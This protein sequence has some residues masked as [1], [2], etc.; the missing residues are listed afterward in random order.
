MKLYKIKRVIR[1]EKTKAFRIARE[2]ADKRRIAAAK[3]VETRRARLE[4]YVKN[5]VI[6]VT[7]L[8]H[9]ALIDAAQ[10][11]FLMVSPSTDYSPP[12]EQKCVN[13]LRHCETAYEEELDAIAGRTGC[14]DAYYEIKA[15]VLDAIADKYEWL[16]LE[17]WRQHTEM[18]R[19]R[20]L[21]IQ[22]PY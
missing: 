1:I 13:F 18:E 9:D 14:K 20:S 6:E 21:D 10:Q 2:K 17:C 19:Q 7:D 5:L 11:N 12:I 16:E 15:K 3:S 8:E 4:E 22:V